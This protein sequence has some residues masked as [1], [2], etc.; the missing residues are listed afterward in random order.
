MTKLF[1]LIIRFIDRI[2]EGLRHIKIPIRLIISYILVSVLPAIVVTNYSCYVVQKSLLDKMKDSSVQI[3]KS[4][5]HDIT[6]YMAD[7]LD[8]SNSIINSTY[9]RK[10]LREYEQNTENESHDVLEHIKNNIPLSSLSDIYIEMGKGDIIHFAPKYSLASEEL[11]RLREIAVKHGRQPMFLPVQLEDGSNGISL[12]R[13]IY[14][15]KGIERLGFIYISA[16]EQS[17]EEIYKN[18]DLGE[19]SFVCLFDSSGKMIS[20]HG[21]SEDYQF[22]ELLERVQSADMEH[23]DSF[24]IKTRGREYA[25]SFCKMNEIDLYI[26]C[27]VPYSYLNSTVKEVRQHFYV[28]VVACLLIC[29]F[30][31]F[32]IYRSIALPLSNLRKHMIKAENDHLIT[33]ITDLNHDE[34]ADV[35]KSFNH[36]IDEINTL[37]DDVQRSERQKSAEKLKALQAQINPHFL[38]NALNT[39]KWMASLQNADNIEKLITSLIQLL[40][41]SMGKAEDLVPL[42]QEIEYIRN[43]IEIQSYKYLDKLA[44][45][46]DID[47]EAEACL[48]PPFSIQPFVENAIIHGIEPK[49]GQGTIWINA[50]RVGKEVVCVIKDNGVGFS[51]FKSWE[52]ADQGDPKHISGIGI[53]NANE[54]IKMFFG[55]DYGIS[56]E[57]IPGIYSKVKMRIPYTTKI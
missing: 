16:T 19:G 37:I 44:V 49:T 40:Q 34:I 56:F 5:N 45:E 13:A 10:F 48:L 20:S 9:M 52:E 32:I 57:S 23:R 54:R 53:K 41:V 14:S 24:D 50:S 36:M 33:K 11:D 26:A 2:S 38:S 15:P 4:I 43:Y 35:A 22:G 28:F 18:I 3:A 27:L 30:F 51:N 8:I 17:L 21:K 1:Y 39:V 31:T 55:E 7:L 29:S 42:S 25:V 46:Y 12:V 47:Q 6:R